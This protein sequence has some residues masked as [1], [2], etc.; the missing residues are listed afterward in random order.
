MP[1]RRSLLTVLCL[2]IFGTVPS[3]A[4][5]KDPFAEWDRAHSQPTQTNRTVARQ[6][7][8]AV[9]EVSS[10][11]ETSTKE[12]PAAEKSAEK[13]NVT[14]FS[15]AQTPP[16]KVESAKPKTATAIPMREK[17]QTRLAV[18][19]LRAEV[20]TAKTEKPVAS[21]SQSEAV[22][23]DISKQNAGKISTVALFTE[24]SEQPRTPGVRSATFSSDGEPAAKKTIRA[25]ADSNAITEDPGSFEEFLGTSEPA[26]STQAPGLDFGN[27]PEEEAAEPLFNREK[28]GSKS[29]VANRTAEPV[30]SETPKPAEFGVAA[31]ALPG[32]SSGPQSP[33]VTL[34][35]VNH[36][37]FNVGQMC[38]VELVIKN[39]SQTVVSSV[40]TEAVI[41]AN[42]EVVE[43]KPAAAEG[44]EMPTWTFGELQPGQSRSVMLKVIPKTRGDVRLDAYVRLT[45]TSSSQFSVQEPMIGVVVSG[46]EEIEVGQQVGY[47]VRVSNP[48][49]GLANNVIIQAAIPEGLEHRN[50]SLLTI[51]IGTLNP[52]ESR[53]ARLSLTAVEGGDQQL[54]VRV[55]ADG[56]L[57]DQTTTAISVAEPQLAVVLAGPETPMAGRSED[58]KLS[59]SNSGSVQSTNVRAKY[60][61]PDGCTFVS[62]DRGGKFV[63]VDNAVEWFVGTLQPNDSSDFIVT[64]K[65]N[66][67]G[68]VVHKAGVMSERGQVTT[69]SL[70]SDVI[71]T[72][73]L[74]M[75]I[76]ADHR[77]LR[78]GQEI[79]WET[80]IRNSGTREATNVGVSC[81]LPAG[82]EFIDAEGPTKY[83][84]ENGVLI[85]RS[86]PAI[87]A[88]TDVK[89]VIHG[90]CTREGSQRL[91]LR[92][93]SESLTDALIGEESASVSR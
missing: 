12:L 71:G 46:P 31:S 41:P 80:T 89:I 25:V 87:D 49:T 66:D 91:R 23:I 14:Y 75:K 81:E 13:A 26:P 68:E 78:V 29:P 33:G 56:G 64:L 43:A 60:I 74:N 8:P 65:A 37:G 45:G 57:S 82:F 52:G 77:E 72:A 54:A 32:V 59:V 88:E 20:Q 53:Q 21:R 55:L 30:T 90:R 17:T 85:F 3:V 92:V 18:E 79:R 73:V 42:V 11:V 24:E 1:L 50:G 67:T 34:Q 62:A 86:I 93:A 48:G 38:N 63:E 6:N 22:S 58:Y 2:A 76:A 39:T 7:V 69:C 19:Q 40:M 61:I 16:L 35:W 4:Q 47:V 27:E 83:I 84:A 28:S 44:A 9:G 51:E 15:A 10:S 70:A 36:G 5:E